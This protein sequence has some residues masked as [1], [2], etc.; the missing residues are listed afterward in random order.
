MAET[1]GFQ[2]DRLT[3]AAYVLIAWFALL[4]AATGLVV[5]H[6]R[7]ELGLSFSVGGLHVAGFAAGSIIAGVVAARLERGLGRRRLLWSA[8]VVMGAGTIALTMGRAAP[9]TIGAALVMGFGGALL[10]VTAQAALSD[11]H[12][13]LR[14]VALAEAN[15]AASIAYVALIGALSLATALNA[16]WRVPLLA[17]LAIPLVTWVVLRR[18]EIDAPLPS[19]RHRGRLPVAFWIAA[20]MLLC[21]TAAE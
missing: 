9:V 19:A 8:A 7:S 5:A 18:L 13:E 10:L 20:A 1:L 4:Q 12:G 15:V 6:L 11:R 17:S 2:R 16:G 3:W 14:P 21:T